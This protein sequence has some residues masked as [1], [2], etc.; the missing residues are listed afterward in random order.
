MYGG[1][2]VGLVLFKYSS[3][4]PSWNISIDSAKIN[5]KPLLDTEWHQNIPKNFGLVP[6]YAEVCR[7]TEQKLRPIFVNFYIVVWFQTDEI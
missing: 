3:F 7:E 5:Q 1:I 4:M 2:I 6:R